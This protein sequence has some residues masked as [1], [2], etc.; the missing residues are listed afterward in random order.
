[1]CS[2]SE[3]REEKKRF[4]NRFCNRRVVYYWRNMKKEAEVDMQKG[5]EYRT[6][7]VCIDSY[8]DGV[9]AG[10]Y[11]NPSCEGEAF[12]SLTQFLVKMEKMLDEMRFPQS[13]TAMR[14]FG[15]SPQ[16][17]D[18]QPAEGQSQEGKLATFAVRI[19]FRQ[20]ASWQGA[21]TWLENGSE[22]YFRSVLELIMLMNSAMQNR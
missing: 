6:T 12:Q 11:Y 8:R 2:F 15:A 10:R 4:C 20:N 18:S 13:F 9:I 21:V 22:E 1:M 7:L 16:K 5:N 19:L 17:A 3:K 14:A